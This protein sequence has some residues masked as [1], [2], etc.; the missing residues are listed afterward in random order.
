[1]AAGLTSNFL[2]C[3]VGLGLLALIQQE[4]LNCPLSTSALQPDKSD[5]WLQLKWQ[6]VLACTSVLENK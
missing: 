1:M 2:P 6:M 3:S 4:E 5:V